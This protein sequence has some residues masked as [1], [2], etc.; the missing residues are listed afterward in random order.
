M[1]LVWS[2]QQLEGREGFSPVVWELEVIL[3]KYCSPIGESYSFF[4]QTISFLC[5][6]H[7][8]IPADFYVA[9]ASW[10]NEMKD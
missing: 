10:K 8:W 2:V 6:R 4:L 3:H 5:R 1:Q 9:E 7:K